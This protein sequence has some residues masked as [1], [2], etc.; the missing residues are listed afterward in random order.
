MLAIQSF[1]TLINRFPRHKRSPEAYL[2]IMELYRDH[3]REQ[4]HNPD[5]LPLAQ[6]TLRK[7]R[8]DFPASPRLEE[9]EGVIDQ[10]REILAEALVDTG[11]FFERAGKAIAACV[12]YRNAALEYGETGAASYSA[13]RL[14]ALGQPLE[15]QPLEGGTETLAGA[16]L[17]P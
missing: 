4:P 1:Q 6:V 17:A 5:L 7:F 13:E 16:E 3:C 9:A 10:M 2:A 12:Y 15:G 11:R 14:A 8:H